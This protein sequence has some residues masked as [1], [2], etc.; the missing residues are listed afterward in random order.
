MDDES[1]CLCRWTAG[2]DSGCVRLISLS[3]GA[4]NPVFLAFRLSECEVIL[5][6][7]EHAAHLIIGQILW[8]NLH[9]IGCR[10]GEA[11]NICVTD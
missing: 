8:P 9:E 5:D 2:G 6:S 11:L 4:S 3:K 1:D 7:D 10:F